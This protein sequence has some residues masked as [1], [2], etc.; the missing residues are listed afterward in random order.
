M[1]YPSNSNFKQL[2]RLLFSRE[3]AVGVTRI[4][5]LADL[6]DQFTDARIAEIATYPGR[7]RAVTLSAASTI[8]NEFGLESVESNRILTAGAPVG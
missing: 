4:D 1:P 5:L 7:R 8:V 3:E 2:S 6:R